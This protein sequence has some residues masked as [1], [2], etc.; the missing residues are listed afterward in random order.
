VNEA[1]SKYVIPRKN[2][3][4]K[5]SVPPVSLILSEASRPH[6]LLRVEVRS[7]IPAGGAGGLLH[8]QWPSGHWEV[9]ETA[10]VLMAG[11][12]GPSS[13][14]CRFSASVLRQ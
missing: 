2:Q 11:G 14:R 3:H 8:L 12:S 13:F 1:H 9:R 6:L 7:A 5:V 4:G 10:G